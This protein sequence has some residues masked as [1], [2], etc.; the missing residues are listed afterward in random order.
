MFQIHRAGERES[1]RSKLSSLSLQ[2]PWNACWLA[3]ISCSEITHKMCTKY[4]F[5]TF[6]KIPCA[7]QSKETAAFLCWVET[8]FVIMLNLWY[9]VSECMW[10]TITFNLIN[11]QFIAFPNPSVMIEGSTI[12]YFRYSSVETSRSLRLYWKH[13]VATLCHKKHITFAVK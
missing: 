13:S 12:S 6:G 1:T 9:I 2:Q 10:P 7:T 11:Q 3:L 4:R 8:S 5:C